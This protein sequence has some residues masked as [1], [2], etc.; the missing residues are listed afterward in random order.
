[1]TR[2]NIVFRNNDM[3]KKEDATPSTKPHS[4]KKVC[5][6]CLQISSKGTN[7]NGKEPVKNSSELK[8]IFM[9][10]KYLKAFALHASQVARGKQHRCNVTE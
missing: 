4:R 9:T 8:S 7:F 1:M 2:Y 5:L 3:M 10:Q 6:V